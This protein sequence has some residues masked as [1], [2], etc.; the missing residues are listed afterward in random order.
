MTILA[1]DWGG[2]MMSQR[3]VEPPRGTWP[4]RNFTKF[5]REEIKSSAS[6]RDKHQFML[7]GEGGSG[8]GRKGPG[9][10][11]GP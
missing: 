5:N 9:G 3:V 8:K 7:D 10:A 2:W 4:G 1:P 11:G 6:E